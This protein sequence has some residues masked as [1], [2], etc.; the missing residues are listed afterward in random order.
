MIYS[1]ANIDGLIDK[2]II[3]HADK[4]GVG[5]VSYDLKTKCFYADNR[6]YETFELMPGDSIFVGSVETVDLPGDLVASVLLRNRWIR[7]G[8][9]LDAPMYFPGHE[10]RFFFRLTNLSGGKIDLK[11]TEGYAQVVFEQITGGGQNY[12]G[13][14]EKEFTFRGVGNFQLYKSNHRRNEEIEERVKASE[15]RIAESEQRV[16]VNVLAILSIIVAVFSIAGLNIVARTTMQIVVHI[17]LIC[18]AFSLLF[19]LLTMLVKQSERFEKIWWLP[20]AIVA[21]CTVALL[22]IFW[23]YPGV[24]D[25][26]IVSN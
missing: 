22:L 10:T 21:L 13:S 16:Y 3:K 19:G 18:G 5:V 17:L 25:M 2:S 20:W 9:L 14:Y 8:L 6:E 4:N 26:P 11:N 7:G 23:H 15:M 12:E 24:M 1:K